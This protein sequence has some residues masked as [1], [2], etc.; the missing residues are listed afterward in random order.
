M[1]MS[2]QNSQKNSSQKPASLESLVDDPSIP[3]VLAYSAK[4]YASAGIKFLGLTTAAVCSGIIGMGAA[5]LAGSLPYGAQKKIAPFFDL[6]QKEL[7]CWNMFGNVLLFPFATYLATGG[8]YE[9]VGVFGVELFITHSRVSQSI[10]RSVKGLERKFKG[11]PL[12]SAPAYTLYATF[13]AA[14]AIKSATG[15]LSKKVHAT[16]VQDKEELQGIRIED[17][18]R[19]A[20]KGSLTLDYGLEQQ[21]YTL[22]FATLGANLSHESHLEKKFRKMKYKTKLH[23]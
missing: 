6:H 23:K 20:E 19:M 3:I 17:K 14:K 7:A 11:H 1:I 12:V 9:S 22:S 2:T 21:K 13:L 5:Y 10:D 8:F 16:Y 18:V 15:K 4:K